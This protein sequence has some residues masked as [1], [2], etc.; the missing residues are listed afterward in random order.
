MFIDM[1]RPASLPW[2]TGGLSVGRPDE[3][4]R[5]ARLYDGVTTEVV[6][7]DQVIQILGSL[8]ILA[9]F[10]AAQRGALSQNSRT[11][12]VLNLVG[13]AVLAVL[14]AYEKQLGFLLLETCWALVSAWGLFQALRGRE[15]TAAGH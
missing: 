15:P 6:F 10:A 13:S 3:S 5:C 2:P 4:S 9:A 14:A 1:G 7:M 12:L 11:Y 8:L